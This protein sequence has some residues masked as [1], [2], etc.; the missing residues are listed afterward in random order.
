[1]LN[2]EAWFRKQSWLLLWKGQGA[3]S[4]YLSVP[5][6]LICVGLSAI[7]SPESQ[8]ANLC[9]LSL[10]IVIGIL[11]M[12]VDEIGSCRSHR[13]GLLRFAAANSRC[14]IEKLGVKSK[15]IDRFVDTLCL[16][17]ELEHRFRR[18][19]LHSVELMVQALDILSRTAS[20]YGRRGRKVFEVNQGALVSAMCSFECLSFADAEKVLVEQLKAWLK[21]PP[22][23]DPEGWAPALFGRS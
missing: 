6:L 13:L 23:Y 10:N 18:T 16:N 21:D 4:S 17:R 1:M 7:S 2:L 9:I 22:T 12:L 11:L 15:Q 8:V 20:R 14:R 19:P 5:I 3:V